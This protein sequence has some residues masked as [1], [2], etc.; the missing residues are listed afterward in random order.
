MH[1]L[2]HPA[3]EAWPFPHPAAEWVT[4]CSR[5]EQRPAEKRCFFGFFCWLFPP[6]CRYHWNTLWL[7]GELLQTPEGSAWRHAFRLFYYWKNSWVN[8]L[9]VCGLVLL[10]SDELTFWSHPALLQ[11]SLLDISTFRE[12]IK[13]MKKKNLDAQLSR[14]VM[15]WF[16]L[17]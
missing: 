2:I 3:T 6:L 13:R 17:K 7:A 10:S 11:Q 5:L 12:G 14:N 4:G 8:L 16:N 1:V 15:P 9:E